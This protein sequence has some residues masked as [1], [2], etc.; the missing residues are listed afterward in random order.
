MW[1]EA[2]HACSQLKRTN[3]LIDKKDLKESIHTSSFFTASAVTDA[4]VV[5]VDDVVVVLF[6]F[7]SLPN[8]DVALTASAH[9]IIPIMAAS[10]Q[11]QR[12]TTLFK[13]LKAIL[14]V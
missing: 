4:I 14:D 3:F 9:P 5:V 8:S 11:M 6:A 1:L 13:I 7:G 10:K 2:T 12:K